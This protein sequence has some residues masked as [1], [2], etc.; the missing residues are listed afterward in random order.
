LIGDTLAGHIQ[1][2]TGGWMLAG[3]ST[4]G[5]LFGETGGAFGLWGRGDNITRFELSAADG[6]MRA[7]AGAVVVDENG[8]SIYSATG[9]YDAAHSLSFRQGITGG[10]VRSGYLGGK[11]Q[12]T[13]SYLLLKTEGATG[14]D[15]SLALEALGGFQNT[16]QGNAGIS[17]LAAAYTGGQPSQAGIA[18]TANPDKRNAIYCSAHDGYFGIEGIGLL[19]GACGETDDVPPGEI[20]ADVGFSTDAGAQKWALGGYTGQAVTATGHVWVNI[21]GVLRKLLAA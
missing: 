7:G 1:L 12:I 18:L 6:R 17:I 14:Q 13:R 10:E 11:A 5:V 4:A 8:V 21:N 19:V 3:G 16:R 2:V 20:W 9:A 15:A